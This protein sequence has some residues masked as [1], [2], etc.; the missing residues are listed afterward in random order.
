[1]S[2][3]DCLGFSSTNQEVSTVVNPSAVST[4]VYFYTVV[5]DQCT[6]VA[7]YYFAYYY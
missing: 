4:T 5:Q 3:L 7:L 6:I 1:M 2:L